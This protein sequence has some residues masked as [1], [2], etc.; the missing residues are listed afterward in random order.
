I[1][2]HLWEDGHR[3]YTAIAKDVGLSEASVRQRVARMIRDRIF[4]V[5]VIAS[6]VE[7]GYVAAGLGLKV[8]EGSLTE[9]AVRIAEFPEVDFVSVCTGSCD[10]NVGVNCEDHAKLYEF[11]TDK[12]RA[13][14]GIETTEL[15]VHVHV[16][17][18]EFG[19]A[20]LPRTV[21]RLPQ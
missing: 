20:P 15:H 6:A 1:I 5:T 8:R 19:V 16:V 10:L 3:P 21:E 18:N 12:I 11:L 4:R 7:L 2:T 17:K 14:P 13:I 9:V